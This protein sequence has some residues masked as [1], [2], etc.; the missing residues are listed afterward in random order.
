MLVLW[1]KYDPSLAIAGAMA[2]QRDAPG[3]DT[4]VLDAGHFALEEKADELQ[5]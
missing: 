1:G 5:S 3:A 4:H 2:Y